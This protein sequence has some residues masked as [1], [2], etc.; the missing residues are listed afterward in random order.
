[1]ETTKEPNDKSCATAL[2]LFGA[3]L[4]TSPQGFQGHEA[5]G[6]EAADA[7]PPSTRRYSFKPGQGS[8]N[9]RPG[10][11]SPLD[12]I[13]MEELEKLDK[14][15]LVVAGFGI[16]INVVQFIAS[17]SHAWA[18]TSALRGGQLFT[19]FLSLDTVQFGTPEHPN[20]DNEYF[21]SH[22]HA[23]SLRTLCQAAGSDERFAN[24]GALKN[25][26][27]DNWCDFEAAGGLTA[28]LMGLGFLVGLI[29]SGITAMY[30]S[31]SI[32]WVALQFDKIEELGFSDHIQK[33]VMC[34]CWIAAWCLIFA[35]MVAYAMFIPD[36]LGWDGVGL[37]ISFGLMRLCFVLC[38]F[39]AALMIN[40]LF[41][42]EEDL[43]EE[44]KS[45]WRDFNDA[46]WLSARKWLYLL[47][48]TQLV[49]YFLLMVVEVDWSAL[50]IV[51]AAYYLIANS[52]S[53][54]I[55]YSVLVVVNLLLVDVVRAA[56]MPNYQTM[57]P[58]ERYGAALWLTI[59]A[60]KLLVL[61]TIIVQEKIVAPKEGLYQA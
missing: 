12:G 48:G 46:S 53:F 40:S 22:R 32:P 47:L 44:V 5:R 13:S 2:S 58:G 14:M 19:A 10:N 55:L 61:I 17:N 36:T 50:L 11:F 4:T 23:C 30:A 15:M 39:N 51:L 33:S 41:H 16:L 9:L 34:A 3:R 35:T 25:T 42:G 57:A 26:P 54:M 8:P 28:T 24:S 29:A 7:M 6:G 56:Q 37:D 1:M 21:C 43:P 52:R 49:C 60:L 18:S 20:R 45:V 27:P 59:V 38:S 31:Q